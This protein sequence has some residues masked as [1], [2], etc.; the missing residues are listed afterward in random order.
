MSDKGTQERVLQVLAH[1]RSNVHHVCQ[2]S[3]LNNKAAR[4]TLAKLCATGL[5]T[6]V[7]RGLYAI[8]STGLDQLDHEYPSEAG[9]LNTTEVI[10][11]SPTIKTLRLRG[12]RGL[13]E[14][15]V[16]DESVQTLADALH[17]ILSDTH[18][19]SEIVELLKQFGKQE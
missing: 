2:Q 17:D 18:T 1:G 19:E 5:V 7:D 14:L 16:D 9:F 13:V 15:Q 4:E 12:D 6:E 8:T 10:H 11:D 3:G